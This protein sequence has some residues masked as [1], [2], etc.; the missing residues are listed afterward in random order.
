V[1]E[2]VE[3]VV[4]SGPIERIAAALRRAQGYGFGCDVW[5]A[6]EYGLTVAQLVALEVVVP[7]KTKIPACE[8][9]GCDWIAACAHRALFADR[10]PG[11]AGRKFTLTL[12]GERAVEDP[13]AL[14]AWVESLPL[15]ERIVQALATADGPLSPF[16]LYWRLLEP[17][18]ATLDA[19][20]KPD[21]LPLT[22]PFVR[23][24]LDLLLAV[25]LVREADDGSLRA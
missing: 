15:S 12:R 2:P 5:A 4:G 7:V 1:S 17:Q 23:F 25:G 3:H 10:G 20:E 22:R 9:H 8:D 16:E 14:L 13:D 24:H 6:S 11:R 19:G 21:D 18:L